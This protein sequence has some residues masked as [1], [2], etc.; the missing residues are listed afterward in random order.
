MSALVERQAFNN[1]QSR[2]DNQISEE[3]IDHSRAESW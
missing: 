2:N 3:V 1:K